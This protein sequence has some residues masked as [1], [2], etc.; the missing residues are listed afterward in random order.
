MES[1][2]H[3]RLVNHLA[4]L[5]PSPAHAAHRAVLKPLEMQLKALDEEGSSDVLVVKELDV[6]EL[7]CDARGGTPAEAVAGEGAEGIREGIEGD[8]VG[9]LE[10]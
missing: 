6:L 9:V 7:R 5:L 8:V 3:L 4:I 10:M 2:F 1:D